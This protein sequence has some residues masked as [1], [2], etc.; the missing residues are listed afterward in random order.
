MVQSVL[1]NIGK[2]IKVAVASS[3]TTA[4]LFSALMLCCQVGVV[5][6]QQ[7]KSKVASC[8]H[9]S[10]ANH[11]KEPNTKSSSCCKISKD[12]PDQAIKT[13]EITKPSGKSFLKIFLD[14]E[15]IAHSIYQRASFSLAYQGPP[16]ANMSLPVYLQL[17]NLRL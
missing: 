2:V 9:T 14:A 13:F 17:S 1:T 8:C 15:R 12:S 5:Q 6:A 7:L 16:R 10:K 11:L 4:F 3:A